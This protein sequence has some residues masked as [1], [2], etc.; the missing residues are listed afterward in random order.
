MGGV[1]FIGLFGL[2]YKKYTTFDWLCLISALSAILLWVLTNNPLL[3]IL[4]SILADFLA[5][6][7]TVVKAYKDST[8]ESMRAYI[9]AGILG[10]LSVFSTEIFNLANTIWPLYIIFANSLVITSWFLGK[11]AR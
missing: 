8:S 9:L 2:G 4:L 11:R 10:I 5:S 1:F 6:L 7:P 3:A